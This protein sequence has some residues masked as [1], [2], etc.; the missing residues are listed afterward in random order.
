MLL[1]TGLF[2]DVSAVMYLGNAII[3]WS[4]AVL[5]LS[6][7]IVASMEKATMALD[8]ICLHRMGRYVLRNHGKSLKLEF[9]LTCVY[10]LWCVT[11]EHSMDRG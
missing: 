10:E 8:G 6:Q 7:S 3:V 1:I 5:S 11:C 4:E 2:A 9:E